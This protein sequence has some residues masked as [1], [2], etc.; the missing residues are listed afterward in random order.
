LLV[1]AG[2]NN[3]TGADIIKTCKELI[4]RGL[5]RISAQQETIERKATDTLKEITALMRGSNE[6]LEIKSNI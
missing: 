6:I 3:F 2:E 5:R 1:Y 4:R